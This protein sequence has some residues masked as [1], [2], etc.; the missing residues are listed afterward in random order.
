M[1]IIFH[2]FEIARS[3]CSLISN[4]TRAALF[5]TSGKKLDLL[6]DPSLALNKV[7]INSFIVGPFFENMGPHLKSEAMTWDI[8]EGFSKTSEFEINCRRAKRNGG[9]IFGM[10]KSTQYPLNPGGKLNVPIFRKEEGRA[11]L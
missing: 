7:S 4:G 5:N 8:G 1:K 11:L 10:S 2:I 6:L 9:N 3:G